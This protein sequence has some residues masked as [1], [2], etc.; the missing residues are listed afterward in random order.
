MLIDIL[1]TS[2]AL[3]EYLVKNT[4]VLD[5]VIA[6][7]FWEIWPSRK[8]LS[9]ELEIIL[10]SEMDYEAKLDLTRRWCK[11]WQFKIGVHYLRSQISAKRAGLNTRN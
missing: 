10:K 2:G 5:S 4:D 7:E 3:S 8:F 6:P 9:S 1:G 11:E